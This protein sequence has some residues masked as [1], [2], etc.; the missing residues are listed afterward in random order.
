MPTWLLATI[1][2]VLFE[3]VTLLFRFGLKM[4]STRDTNFLS[5]LTF[6]YRIHHG[7]IG[8]LIALLAWLWP[9]L[10]S[11]YSNW[12]LALGLALIASDILHHFVFLWW[13]TGDPHF[14]FRY[15]PNP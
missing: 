4:E 15:P 13:L 1:L 6:G 9:D 3:G 12:A 7:Y 2:T 8:V 5:I 14:D 10:L 11:K